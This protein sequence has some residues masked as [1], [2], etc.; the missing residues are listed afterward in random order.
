M[1]WGRENLGE[2]LRD[3]C[4]C[5]SYL[6]IVIKSFEYDLSHLLHICKVGT[7]FRNKSCCPPSASVRNVLVIESREF[8]KY[9]ILM[10]AILCQT[11][12]VCTNY[13][14]LDFILV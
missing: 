8:T 9:L 1:P 10:Y 14:S 4:F 2:I 13:Q 7:T 3:K 11:M 5:I 12:S 6:V